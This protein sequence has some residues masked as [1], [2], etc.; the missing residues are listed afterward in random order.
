V[1]TCSVLG[2]VLGK[3]VPCARLIIVLSGKQ[4]ISFRLQAFFGRKAATFGVR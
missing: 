2:P 1:C 4:N 3:I